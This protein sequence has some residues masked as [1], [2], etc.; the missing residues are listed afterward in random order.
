M[1][2]VVIADL[3]EIGGEMK[4]A[5]RMNVTQMMVIQD[6]Y[7]GSDLNQPALCDVIGV[8][9]PTINR[10]MTA[11]KRDPESKGYHVDWL[12]DP[13]IERETIIAS[14]L[15]IAQLEEELA[16]RNNAIDELRSTVG[17]QQ[18]EISRLLLDLENVARERD[19]YEL[20]HDTDTWEFA[21]LEAKL[22]KAREDMPLRAAEVEEKIAELQRET[23]KKLA[24][25]EARLIQARR[26]LDTQA[27]GLVEKAVL[28]TAWTDSRS[29]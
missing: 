26:N 13:R 3:K 12:P 9:V 18:E 15:R 27:R 14:K 20:V 21:Q 6:A 7:V 10:Y 5:G 8:S 19:D 16:G 24:A 4:D 25:A 17:V 11:L 22:R 29:G 1:S 23:T 2:P 28:R